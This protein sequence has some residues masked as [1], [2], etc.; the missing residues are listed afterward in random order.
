MLVNPSSEPELKSIRERN[1]VV[2]DA[3][4]DKTSFYFDIS[5]DVAYN[6]IFLWK[7]SYSIQNSHNISRLIR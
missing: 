6:K 1:R 2:N 3:S 4:T 7:L 5:V